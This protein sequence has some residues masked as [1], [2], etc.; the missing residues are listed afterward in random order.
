MHGKR[1]EQRQQT[2]LSETGQGH[3]TDA[4][5]GQVLPTA[6]PWMQATGPPGKVL[7]SGSREQQPPAPCSSGMLPATRG[8]TG[9]GRLRG[10]GPRAPRALADQG[11]PSVG[12]GSCIC[13]A[14][15]GKLL[16]LPKS[17]NCLQPSLRV[18]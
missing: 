7:L 3:P 6:H 15:P 2:E 13:E 9:A 14:T 12:P 16:F 5:E 11:P 18:T 1:T 10:S 17:K 8:R 4:I